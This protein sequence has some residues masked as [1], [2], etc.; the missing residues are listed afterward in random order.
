MARPMA[1]GRR[2]L[3]GWAIAPLAAAALAACG[4]DTG[5]AEGGKAAEPSSRTL[6]ETVQGGDYDTLGGTLTNAG[7]IGVLEGKGPYTL[8]AP[9]DAAFAAAAGGADFTNEAMR[10]QGAALLR[11][12]IVPGA[13]T[14]T[15]IIK[16]LDGAGP[17]GVKMRTMADTLLTFS[18]DGETIVVTSADGARARLTSEASLASNGVLHPI[19]GLLVKPTAPGA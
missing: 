5:K 9:A 3:L 19:D 2:R 8:F 15:D 16:A 10:A 1:T 18:R 14:R 11:A 17:G 7:L 12:H 4:G 6:A 13:L